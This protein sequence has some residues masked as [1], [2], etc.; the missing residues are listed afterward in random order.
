[1]RFL[2][3]TLCLIT[4]GCRVSVTTTESAEDDRA[5]RELLITALDSWKAGKVSSL[6]KRTP[7]VRFTDDDLRAG[8]RLASYELADPEAAVRPFQNTD[9]KL[10]LVRGSGPKIER[11]ASYQVSLKPELTVLR[12]DP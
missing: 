5:A 6:R 7:P 10:V 3:I 8:F 2:L 11:L 12:S 9:V 1:M 4:A